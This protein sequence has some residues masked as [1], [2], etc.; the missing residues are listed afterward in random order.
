[1]KPPQF[2]LLCGLLAGCAIV[3]PA[4]DDSSLAGYVTRAASGSD[5]DINGHRVV[6]DG[7]TRTKLES[8]NGAKRSAR[9]CPT[10][11]P[12]I[13][14]ALIAYSAMFN[15]GNS[16]RAHLIESRRPGHPEIAGSAV[17]DAA[18]AQ[19][20]MEAQPSA[21]CVRADGYL[22]CSG[23]NTRIEWD[24]PFHSPADLRAGSWIK[25]KGKMD[26]TGQV[27]ASSLEIGVNLI[28]NREQSL[29]AGNEYDPAAV[30]ADARQ[31]YLKV[32]FRGGYD[33]K[34]F[35]PFEDAAMQARV[36]QIGSS[37]I[38]PYQRSLPDSDPAKIRFRFQ[39]VDNKHF[40]GFMPC[41]TL[42]LPSGI[43]LVPHQ[44]VER[45]QN[46]SQLAAVLADSIARAL[47]KQQFRAEGEH[48]AATATTLAGLFVPYAGS[49]M[50]AGGS[51]AE[52]KILTR[53]MEQSGRVSLTLLRDAGYELNQAPMAWWLLAADP[54]KTLSE[55]EM[56]DRAGYLYRILGEA[57]N[58]PAAS[59]P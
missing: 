34:K 26:P 43:V 9:G 56:P 33:P 40:C 21:F 44:V 35:P 30:P 13:G 16:I 28:A 31:N 38:P 2:L 12:F 23:P 45:M 54:P 19:N 55:T 7:K 52:R 17:I 24:L 49:G 20:V 14:E 27:L 15:G 48:F 50:I 36:E 51:I 4:Q 53:A 29:R 42:T 57:W 6:C 8:G 46:D 22:V 37:L 1:M 5:F 10:E 11:T 18:P 41:D 47:E 39:V 59:T 32:A 3:S 25:Y 58:C